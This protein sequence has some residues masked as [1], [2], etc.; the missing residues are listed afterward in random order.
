MR[1]LVRALLLLASCSGASGARPVECHLCV[2]FAPSGACAFATR[3]FCRLFT[4]RQ[5]PRDRDMCAVER[6][7]DPARRCAYADGTADACEGAFDYY[8][9]RFGLEC[10][11]DYDDE[12]MLL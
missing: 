2:Q 10:D 7:A 11:D 3:G 6:L 1:R 5:N 8:R 12:D 4:K 9:G